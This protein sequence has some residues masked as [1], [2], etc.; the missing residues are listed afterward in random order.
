MKRH[1]YTE[2]ETSFI[3]ANYQTMSYKEIGVIIGVSAQAIKDKISS[4]G[5]LKKGSQDEYRQSIK[6]IGSRRRANNRY[7]DI[8]ARVNTTDRNKNK[9]Y[10]NVKLLVSRRDFIE[11]YMP[12]DF[13]GASVDRIDKN[14]DYC[15]NNMQVIPLIDN[16]RKDHEKAY[17]GKCV[18]YKCKEEK[19][20]ELFVKD[21]RRRNGYATICLDCERERCRLKNRKYRSKI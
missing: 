6:T 13:E 3:I 4:L 11:W 16:I 15:L 5:L 20:L 12:R 17:D 2:A 7:N 9:S 8:I 1:H 18:C 19:P 14:G 10:Q 21:K